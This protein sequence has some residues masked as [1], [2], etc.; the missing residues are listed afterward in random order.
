MRLDGPRMIHSQRH[1]SLVERRNSEEFGDSD[2]HSDSEEFSD[3]DER[4]DS[5]ECSDFGEHSNSERPSNLARSSHLRFKHDKVSH[6]E[7]S[8]H[9]IFRYRL[10]PALWTYRRDSD[11]G[12]D[13]EDLLMPLRSPTDILGNTFDKNCIGQMKLLAVIYDAGLLHF[14]VR[15][16]PGL[17][18]I[19]SL[20]RANTP[21]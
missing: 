10:G 2:E 15:K 11:K 1:G 13:L 19:I 21:T 17:S 9:E 5:G 8:I 14:P 12:P 4:S 6:L 16:D 20:L 18:S 7:L 3:S